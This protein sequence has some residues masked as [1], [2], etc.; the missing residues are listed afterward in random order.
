METLIIKTIK[1]TKQT[2]L[3]TLRQFAKDMKKIFNEHE[4]CLI[5]HAMINGKK[6]SSKLATYK[7]K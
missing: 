2:E 4:L 1:A 7:V 6:I 3:I 5:Q